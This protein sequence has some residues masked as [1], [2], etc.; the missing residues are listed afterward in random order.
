MVVVEVKGGVGD[1]GLLIFVHICVQMIHQTPSDIM[2]KMSK[3]C[4][5]R[6]GE[7]KCMYGKS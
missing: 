7:N 4:D 5:Y 2:V 3:M 6:D 1:A